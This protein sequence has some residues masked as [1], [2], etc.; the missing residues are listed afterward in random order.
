MNDVAPDT[1]PATN[2]AATATAPPMAIAVC[3]IFTTLADRPDLRPTSLGANRAGSMVAAC[4]ARS[5]VVAVLA[6]RLGM[7]AATGLMSALTGPRLTALLMALNSPTL[8]PSKQTHP[9]TGYSRES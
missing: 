1:F 8:A 5:A 9:V 6:M 3:V 2:G 7:M 4:P